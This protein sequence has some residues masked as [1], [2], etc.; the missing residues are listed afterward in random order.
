MAGII[1]AITPS[2]PNAPTHRRARRG[3]HLVR[4]RSRNL[5]RERIGAGQV[6]LA[7]EFEPVAHPQGK[8]CDRRPPERGMERRRHR[9]RCGS[10]HHD[11][12]EFANDRVRLE[13]RQEPGEHRIEVG[14]VGERVAHSVKPRDRL[15]VAIVE[16]FLVGAHGPHE[17]LARAQEAPGCGNADPVEQIG[18]ERAVG[19]RPASRRPPC[20]ASY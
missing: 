10:R 8:Q 4:Q 12:E 7:A 15:A 3:A 19:L 20:G 6:E 2:L 14:V 18:V 17:A 5:Q 9:R 11:A 16:C 13:P 1:S